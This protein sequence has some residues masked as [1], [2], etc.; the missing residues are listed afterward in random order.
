MSQT[1]Y[2]AMKRTGMV[3]RGGGGF[4][5]VVYPASTDAY[6]SARPGSVYAEFDVPRSS[7]IPGGR[8]GDFKMSDST[9]INA[10]LAAKRGLPPPELPAA[11]NLTLGGGSP[12]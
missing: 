9:T 4:T 7:L 8:P 5:Y 6:I 12:C 3:Q 1:E 2:D 11:K 10:R